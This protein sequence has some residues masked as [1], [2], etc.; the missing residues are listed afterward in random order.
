MPASLLPFCYPTAQY[1]AGQ[2]SIKALA[3]TRKGQLIQ[4][5]QYGMVGEGITVAELQNRCSTAELTR[6]INDMGLLD[7]PIVT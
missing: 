4:T 1:G 5:Y 2:G 7:T 3:G 6:Q